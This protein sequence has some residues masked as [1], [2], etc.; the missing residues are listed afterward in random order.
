MADTPALSLEEARAALIA[1]QA[2]AEAKRQAHADANAAG[3]VAYNDHQA[4]LA[5][6]TEMQAKFEAAQASNA[7][8]PA[9]EAHG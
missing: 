2:D 1:A 5:V 4:A 7:Q 6:V 9:A 3:W 8:D